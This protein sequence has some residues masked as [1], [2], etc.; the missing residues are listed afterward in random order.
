M[1]RTSNAK[2]HSVINNVSLTEFVKRN[3]TNT[4]IY[5]KFSSHVSHLKTKDDEIICHDTVGGQHEWHLSTC[6]KNWVLGLLM[7]TF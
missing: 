1:L 5:A 3:V 6:K 2:L 7:V 4:A